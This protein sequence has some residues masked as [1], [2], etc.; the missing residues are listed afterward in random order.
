MAPVFNLLTAEAFLLHGSP[1]PAKLNH[2]IS[3]L[4]IYRIWMFTTNYGK[5]AR[6][7]CLEVNMNKNGRLTCTKI[8]AGDIGL[9]YCLLTSWLIMCW[10]K[11]AKRPRVNKRTWRKGKSPTRRRK[12]LTKKFLKKGI[13]WEISFQKKYQK[14]PQ[15]LK[16]W[17]H[18]VLGRQKG[19]RDHH[20]PHSQRIF[21]HISM[22]SVGRR[23]FFDHAFQISLNVFSAIWCN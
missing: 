6:L 7:K 21:Y 17:D 14:S 9:R 10:E 12:N 1:F 16:T 23:P 22:G 11:W 4:S 19:W 18:F 5:T 13:L 15:K 3:S 8:L 2:W 20:F